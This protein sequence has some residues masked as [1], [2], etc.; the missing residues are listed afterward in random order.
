M[1]V[2]IPVP[3]RVEDIYAVIYLI[4]SIFRGLGY[5]A[6]LPSFSDI[7]DHPGFGII[8]LEVLITCTLMALYF[9]GH[10][11]FN[12]NIKE[13]LPYPWRVILV[14]VLC[15]RITQINTM[16]IILLHLLNAFRTCRSNISD[17]LPPLN[18]T[19]TQGLQQALGGSNILQLNVLICT[20]TA[21][22]SYGDCSHNIGY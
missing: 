20:N 13:A 3:L 19:G 2:H 7:Q 22:V 15:P 14:L 5:S 9:T 4:C 1:E 10:A 8:A 11:S 21:H 17:N 16:L 6:F 18:A 12:F